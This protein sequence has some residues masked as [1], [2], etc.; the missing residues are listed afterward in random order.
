PEYLA[1]IEKHVNQLTNLVNDLLEISHLESRSGGMRQQ[2][3]KLADLLAKAAD[4]MKPAAEKKKQSLN[5]SLPAGLPAITGDP[6]Y[7]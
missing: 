3:I 5:V 6:D 4:T 2:H 7:L 1:T